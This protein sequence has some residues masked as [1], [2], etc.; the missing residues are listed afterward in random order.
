MKEIKIIEVYTSN[1]KKI[2]PRNGQTLY[3]GIARDTNNEWIEITAPAKVKI[4]NEWDNQSQTSD[5]GMA[6]IL[7][8]RAKKKKK[9]KKLKK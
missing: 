9:S 5:K 4:W 6:L 3:S 7:M 1:G 2:F 8:H